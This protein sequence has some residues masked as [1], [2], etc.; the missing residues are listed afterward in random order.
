MSTRTDHAVPSRRY[1]RDSQ[2]F[3]RLV[4]LSDAVFAIAMTL[5]VLTLETPQVPASELAA[6]LGRE[7]PQLVAFLLSF[8]LVANIWW[9]HHKLF[10]K[11]AW[12]EP[13]IVAINLVLLGAVAL[14]PFPTSL[15][16][17]TPT[18]RAAVAPF[19][20]V[21]IVLSLLYL[22]LMV[23]VQRLGAWTEPVPAGLF[24][25]LAAGFALVVVAMSAALL[26]TWWSPR[27][28]L[29]LLV[30]SNLPERLLARGAPP[31]YDA[32]A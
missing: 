7:L 11:L 16:G 6:A 21:F 18:A 23:R 32:W 1:G 28:A 29:L 19:V 10:A 22:G 13:G 8:A 30:V 5:L 9:Q 12:I 25:W 26:I 3:A 4:N 24:P 15:L 17:S 20:T 2:E 31:G 27:G 14:V